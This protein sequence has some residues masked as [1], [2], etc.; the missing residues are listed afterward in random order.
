[1]CKYLTRISF[2]ILFFSLSSCGSCSQKPP[3]I[4]NIQDIQEKQPTNQK[5]ELESEIKELEIKRKQQITHLMDEWKGGKALRTFTKL[6]KQGDIEAIYQYKKN[7][8]DL[9]TEA[10]VTEGLAKLREEVKKEN[11]DYSFIK[12]EIAILEKD[13]Y[14]LYESYFLAIYIGKN[15]KKGVDEYFNILEKKEKNGILKGSEQKKLQLIR[16]WKAVEPTLKL[17]QAKR[18]ALKQLQEA[19]KA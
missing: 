11:K 12:E 6:L 3:I 14:K 18:E 2:I 13:L 15:T 5:E 19:N 4:Q 7:K 9:A 10:N 17:E 16:N 1:M 8:K